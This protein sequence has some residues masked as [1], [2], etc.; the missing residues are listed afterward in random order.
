MSTIFIPLTFLAGLYG[1][2]FHY[3]P[4]LR[5][6]W[7]YPILL[8]VMLLVVVMLLRYFRERGWLGRNG[9]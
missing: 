8:A 2:N 5:W 9:D 3:M 4:E 7:S 1:M 6:R